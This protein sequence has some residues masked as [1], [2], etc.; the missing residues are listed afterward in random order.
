MQCVAICCSMLQNVSQKSSCYGVATVSR[1]DKIIGLFCRISSL[2]KD[3]FAKE[4]Y[5]LIDPT[6]RSH[7][8]P[9]FLYK[10]TVELT[11]DNLY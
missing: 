11:V 1:I 3:S 5:K 2:L 7:P 9:H 8:I 6:N 4:T 10:N